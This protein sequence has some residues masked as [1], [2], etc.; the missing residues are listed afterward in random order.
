[1]PTMCSARMRHGYFYRLSDFI[2]P[3]HLS[4]Q[5]PHRVISA[6][7]HRRNRIKNAR[8]IGISYAATSL[9]RPFYR[10]VSVSGPTFLG[11][12]RGRVH[13]IGIPYANWLRDLPDGPVCRMLLWGYKAYGAPI[14]LAF[15][16]ISLTQS[17]LNV[18][19]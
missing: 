5:T 13:P 3:N 15:P 10:I 14:V 4:S 8:P 11:H 12:A 9:N 1:M 16:T 7:P 6:R 18:S 17:V 19:R 2:R